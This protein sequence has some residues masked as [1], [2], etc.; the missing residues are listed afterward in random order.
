MNTKTS[1]AVLTVDMDEDG[2]RTVKLTTQNY[3]RVLHV[4]PGERIKLSVQQGRIVF[5]SLTAGATV[6]ELGSL[7]RG[8]NP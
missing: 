4:A 7:M 3:V 1:S 6:M 2:I 8:I 5:E